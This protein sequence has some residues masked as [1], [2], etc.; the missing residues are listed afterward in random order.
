MIKDRGTKKWTS[1]M[2]PEHIG[3][4]RQFADDYYHVEKPIVDEYELVEFDERIAFAMEYNLPVK[5]TVWEAG[6]MSEIVGRSH[7]V[8]PIT[9]QVRVEQA[10]GSFE[11]LNM[12]D[13][14]A[15]EI[16]DT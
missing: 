4:L 2:L 6:R 1:M 9:K 7:Y 15:V 10:D 13:I 12:T 16:E 5:F 8:D 11:R 3:L 14:V